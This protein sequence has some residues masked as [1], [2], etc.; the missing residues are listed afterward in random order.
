LT[1]GRRYVDAQT[2]LAT[3]LIARK[4]D[5][6]TESPPADIARAEGLIGQALAAS[7]RSSQVHFVKAQ[8]LRAQGRLEEAISEYAMVIALDR[9]SVSAIYALGWCEFMTGS[10]EEAIAH[11]EQAIRLSPRDPLI[12]SWYAWIGR[13]LLLQSRT[14]EAILWLEKARGSNAGLAFVHAPRRR[15]CPQRRA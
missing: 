2:W 3:A 5:N 8:V 14:D 9:N 12:A 11:V 10:V 1:H 4:L 13:V 15:L 7:P 6:M